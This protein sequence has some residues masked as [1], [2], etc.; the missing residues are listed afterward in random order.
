MDLFDEGHSESLAIDDAEIFLWR[1][2][3]FGDDRQLLER[4]IRET[5][6]RQDRITLWGK[7]YLQPRLLAWHGDAGAE[8]SYSG[9]TLAPEQWSDL[10]LDIKSKVEALSGASFNSVLVNYY[11]DHRDSMGFHA[12]DEPELGAQPVIASVSLGEERRFVLKHRHRK[13]IENVVLPLPSSSLLLMAGETQRNWK[14]GIPKETRPRGPRVN[15][16]FR[17]IITPS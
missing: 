13:D 2:V 1:H 10:L 4:L 6:W 15:L 9:I 17:T 12:D 16:T 8:Y 5:N 7:S 3:D 14:H 11:R